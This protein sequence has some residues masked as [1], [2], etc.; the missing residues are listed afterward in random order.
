M[1]IIMIMCYYLSIKSH[2]IKV[3]MER[4]SLCV[5]YTWPSR[6]TIYHLN[7]ITTNTTTTTTDNNNNNNNYFYYYSYN[8]GKSISVWVL[9]I[10]RMSSLSNLFSKYLNTSVTY[11]WLL[12]TIIGRVADVI[13]V[14]DY[15]STSACGHTEQ[16]PAPVI[17]RV[18]RW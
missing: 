4:K 7:T 14:N 12:G 3:L 15:S 16:R 11:R 6:I 18:F 2:Q 8:N 5:S 1:S 13:K 17:R 9:N 10:I